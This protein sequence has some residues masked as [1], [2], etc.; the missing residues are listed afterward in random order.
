MSGVAWNLLL[1]LVFVLIGGYFAAAEIALVSLRDSQ[2]HKLEQRSK[3]G[4]R[5]ANL[6]AD[7]NRFLSAVQIG[8]TFAGF[9]ASSYGGATIAVRLEPSLAGWGLPAGLAASVALVVVTL[10][11]SYL[12]LV[13][14]ELVPKRLALHRTEA[15]ALATAD[16]LDRMATLARPL[17]WLLS[18]STNAVVRLLGLDP[19]AAAQ[20]VSEE[21]LRDMVR[22]N[23]Q[24]SVEERHLLTDTFHASGLVLGEVMVPRT[25]VD[26]LDEALPLEEAISEI[27]GKPHSRYPVL[28]D[29]ADH[30]VGFVH[31][32]DLLLVDITAT[33]DQTTRVGDLVRPV[34]SLPTSKP[35]LQALSLMRQ[36]GH[37]TVVIDEYGGT[38]GIVTV[39]DLVEEVVGDI[40]DEY[41]PSAV[42]V[43]PVSAGGYVVDGLLHRDDLAEQVGLT[44]PEGPYDT[45]AGF[46]LSRLGKLPTAGDTLDALGHR[47]TVRAMDG[48]RIAR[49]HVRP[50]DSPAPAQSERS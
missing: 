39:E 23:E 11:V 44:L 1:V 45:V 20:T 30:V 26:F 7:S 8:V 33:S 35:V 15:T 16:V 50:L 47:F 22:T 9:F 43:R 42:P 21:E 36:H 29:T 28:R 10:F 38:A 24:L 19:R 14:G 3:R 18:V 31:V 5:V 25:E 48:H 46:V 37:L 6:R 49:L 12:S 2:L 13:L 27:R 32:R 4:A 40:W 41:D 34:T 17:I